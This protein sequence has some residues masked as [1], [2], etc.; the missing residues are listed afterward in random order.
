MTMNEKTK[1]MMEKARE[2]EQSMEGTVKSCPFRTRFHIMPPVGWINDPNGLCQF[3]GIFHA[4]FQYSPLSVNGGGGFWGHCVSQDLLHW[5]YKEP[6]LTTDIPEDAGGVYSGS[7]LVEDGRLYLFYTGNVK[8]PGDYDYIDAGRISTQILVESPD[9]QHMSQKEKVLEM[10]DYPADITQ[11]VRDPKVW[12]EEGRY[13]MV[14][15]ARRRAWKE[16]GERR[17]EGGVLVYSS[18][19]MHSWSLEREIFPKQY[20]GYMWECPDI[21]SLGEGEEERKILSFS[22]Q[23]LA[24]EKERFQN[25]YQSGWGFLSGGR[26]EETFTEWDMGFDFYAPQTFQA[27]DGRRIL[28]GWAGVPDTQEEHANL[29]VKNGWQHCLTLPRELTLERGRVIQRPVREIFGF[30]WRKEDPSGGEP[31]RWSSRAVRLDIRDISGGS[32]GVLLGTPGN[33]LAIQADRD[34]VTLS[35]INEEGEP[36]ACGGGRKARTGRLEEPVDRLL[37][38]VDSSIAE[39]F[40]NGGEMV[41]T[42]RLYLEK[43]ERELKIEGSGSVT[44]ETVE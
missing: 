21:F 3:Q 26:P 41:F 7:A 34:T 38:L 23:G 13:H 24:H 4:Y 37:I 33:G 43:K 36:S 1:E 20:F 28:I 42:T 10:K 19:D 6:V 25:R 8:L 5:E 15:G 11:H 30:P 29:S 35:Y 39:I 27:E 14:L 16:D 40:V 18:A 9:G 12:K 2:Q 44:L 17:D 32:A 31:F 22:P